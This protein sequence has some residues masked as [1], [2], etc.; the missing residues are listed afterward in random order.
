M[1]KPP[2]ACVWLL[3]FVVV[4]LVFTASCT[5]L[6][7]RQES[8]VQEAL[9][10]AA[11]YLTEGR[12]DEA[13]DVYRAALDEVPDDARLWYNLSLAQAQAGDLASAIATI[14]FLV[15][16]FPENV[17]YLRAQAAILLESGASKEACAVWE[18]VLTLDPFD[19]VVR[20]RLAN[21]YFLDSEFELSQKHALMLYHREQY[22]RELF[23]LCS[24]LEQALGEGDGSVWTLLADAYFP[25]KLE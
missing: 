23:L 12:F 3:S 19:E 17:K 10:E 16:L 2:Q 4:A 8:L 22:S 11:P 7:A 6:P 18:Q 24:R 14:G 13:A 1:Y 25:T 20:L 9:S 21:Q 5:S 15:R